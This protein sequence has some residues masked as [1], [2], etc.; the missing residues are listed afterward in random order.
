MGLP[1]TDQNHQVLIMTKVRIL[2]L[3]AAVLAVCA[4]VHAEGQEHHSALSSAM[5]HFTWGADVGGSIDM[6]GHDMSIID[7]SANF[8][9]KSDILRLLGAGASLNLMVSNSCRSFPFY[10]IIRTSFTRRPS[11]FFVEARAGASI[12]YLQNN[13]NQTGLYLSG[14]V[15][16]N[17]ATGRTFRSHLILSYSFFDRGYITYKDQDYSVPDL[18]YVGVKIGISF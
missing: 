18:H 15:G 4:T 10:A 6:S 9:Y 16:I 12:N 11:L 1:A 14:G 7:I 5:E 3:L 2:T 17:L 8:G 13:I